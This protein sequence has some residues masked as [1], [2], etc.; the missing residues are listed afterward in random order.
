MAKDQSHPIKVKFEGLNDNT[1]ALIK[2]LG[3][4][5]LLILLGLLYHFNTDQNTEAAQKFFEER[6]KVQE[7][8][9]YQEAEA[10]AKKR[11]EKNI[12]LQ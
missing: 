9:K 4:T 2:F 1:R 10:D 8:H 3:I 12:F 5:L 6:K 7:F 11:A